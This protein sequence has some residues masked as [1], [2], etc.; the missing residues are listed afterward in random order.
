[1]LVKITEDHIKRGKRWH[2][3]KCAG[4]LAINDAYGFDGERETASVTLDSL[5]IFTNTTGKLENEEMHRLDMPQELH[6]FVLHYDSC[7][8]R[9][10]LRVRPCEF[11]LDWQR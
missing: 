8:P 2:A 6:D 11:E 9:D 1:M 4:T 10:Q 5:T 7:N 3:H